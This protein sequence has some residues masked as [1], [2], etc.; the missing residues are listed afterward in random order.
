MRE[1]GQS[2]TR[3]TSTSLNQ[4]TSSRDEIPF[5]KVFLR[6][7]TSTI[8]A[9]VYIFATFFM[10]LI[11]LYF[12]S[13]RAS[14]VEV[15]GVGLG[16][17]WWMIIH[18]SVLVGLN[19]GTST[20][21]AQA[22]GALNYSMVALY[23][24]R[25]FI[26]RVINIL[27]SYLLCLTSFY[28]FRLIGVREEVAEVASVYCINSLFAM[29][30]STL[31]DSLRSYI[32]AHN[33]FLP[34]MAVQAFVAFVHWFWCKLFVDVL[35]FGV[36]GPIIAFGASMLTGTILLLAYILLSKE[37]TMTRYWFRRNCFEGLWGQLKN[38][39]FI[40]SFFLLQWVAYECYTLLAGQLQE[41]QIAAQSFSFIIIA[42]I[43][44]PPLALSII[45]T[46]YI[47]NSLGRRDA[48]MARTISKAIF[49]TSAIFCI[50]EALFLVFLKTEIAAFLTSD[51]HIKE[52]IISALLV[53]LIFMPL[54]IFQHAVTGILKG[55]GREKLAA[56]LFL[57]SFYL[58]GLSMAYV[59]GVSIEHTS[60]GIWFGMGIGI[61]S[62]AVMASFLLWKTSYD[63]QIYKIE[64][65][66]LDDEPS[67]RF[68]EEN[69]L[70]TGLN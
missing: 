37:F 45:G 5:S 46:I 13:K 63:Y 36:K 15:D 54:D 56:L 31:Y 17:S 68:S 28:I 65:R 10:L 24:H 40:A 58:V 11:N 64:I 22:Y 9:I 69:M 47:G 55:A 67:Y 2:L 53:Y 29:V 38:E 61:S 57:I 14:M 35:D 23:C 51:E 21:A 20:F 62:M 60:S 25:G 26:L 16:N 8:P 3:G 44:T 43:T 4:S 41:D 48:A 1:S 70:I 49:L 66:M 34:A 6:I 27:P 7:F 32:S 42:I 12:M 30:S 18:L 33:I 19:V 59:F 52:S 39:I 50:L